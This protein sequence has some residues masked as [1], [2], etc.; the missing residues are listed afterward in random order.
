MA[1]GVTSENKEFKGKEMTSMIS[2]NEEFRDTE[3]IGKNDMKA[4]KI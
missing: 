3:M 1:S 2:E 4:R